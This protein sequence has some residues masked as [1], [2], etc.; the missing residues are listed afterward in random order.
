MIDNN[1]QYIPLCLAIDEGL[2]RERDYVIMSLEDEQLS[3]RFMINRLLP[4]RFNLFTFEGESLFSPSPTIDNYSFDLVN[5]LIIN[6][7]L[8]AINKKGEK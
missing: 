6:S 2:I 7:R 3:G 5:N 4:S 8:I 1:K